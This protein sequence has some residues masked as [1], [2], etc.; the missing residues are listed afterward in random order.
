MPSL[1]F[2]PEALVKTLPPPGPTA[3]AGRHGPT[4]LSRGGRLD[5]G[6]GA[7]ASETRLKVVRAFATSASSSGTAGRDCERSAS[8]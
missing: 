2:L 4:V 7:G 5:A 1:I 8:R 6:V 3:S